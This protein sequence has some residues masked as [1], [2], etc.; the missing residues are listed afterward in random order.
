H[1]P[2]AKIILFGSRARGTNKSGADVDVAIDIGERIPLLE[3]Q[4]ARNTME[5][6]FIP[7][8][9]DLV[10]LQ[11]VSAEFKASILSEGIVWQS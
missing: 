5:N 9:V 2:Q 7:L 11:R 1:F 4:R 10:D 8:E 3:L 6:L